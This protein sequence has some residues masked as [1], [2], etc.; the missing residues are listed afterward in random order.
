LRDVGIQ[1]TVAVEVDCMIFDLLIIGLVFGG[2]MATANMMISRGA[3]SQRALS[4]L[5]PLHIV[6][7]MTLLAIAL[8]NLLQNISKIADRIDATPIAAVI[9]LAG[10]TITLLLGLMFAISLVAR[11]IPSNSPM[12]QKISELVTKMAPMQALLGLVA[13]GLAAVLLAQRTGVIKINT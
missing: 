11:W 1:T 4:N 3:N 7:G 5:A 10:I 9:F 2:I 12:D 13:F 8:L 6:L